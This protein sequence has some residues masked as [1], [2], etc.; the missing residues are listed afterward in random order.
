MHKQF[1]V[2]L[3]SRNT[4]RTAISKFGNEWVVSGVGSLHSNKI[5][6]KTKEEGKNGPSDCRWIAETQIVSR[7]WELN[8][9]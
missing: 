6:I 8:P 9:L 5:C 4:E 1:V 2:W 7:R 3:P